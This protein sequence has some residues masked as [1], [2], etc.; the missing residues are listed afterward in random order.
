MFFFCFFFGI[1]SVQV[2]S[3]VAFQVPG[4]AAHGRRSV[5]HVQSAA[6]FDRVHAAVAQDRH[7]IA[8][9]GRSA[10]DALRPHQSAGGHPQSGHSRN[11]RPMPII[12]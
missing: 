7:R 2:S 6:S 9:G 3:A 11:T 1:V 8:A 10:V 12:H 4:V 5:A